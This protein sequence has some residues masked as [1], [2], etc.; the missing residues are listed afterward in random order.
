MNN[1]CIGVETATNNISLTDELPLKHR[2][3]YFQIPRLKVELALKHRRIFFPMPRLQVKLSL[4]Q[5]QIICS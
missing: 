1:N 2:Q 5:R 4:K 3:I